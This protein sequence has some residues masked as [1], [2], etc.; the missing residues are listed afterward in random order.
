MIDCYSIKPIDAATLAAAARETGQL[1]TVEDHW[2][3]GGLGEAVLAALAERGRAPQVTHLAVRDMP[4]SGQAGRAARR[5]RDRRG[6][7]DRR[8]SA[9]A[10]SEH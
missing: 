10:P 3:E 6:D 8:R 5:V 9:V 4:H 7:R 2:P 1:V